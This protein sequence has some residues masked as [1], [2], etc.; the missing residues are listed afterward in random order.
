MSVQSHCG[1][2]VWRS[3]HLPMLERAREL[4]SSSGAEPCSHESASGYARFVPLHDENAAFRP[5]G[6]A[7]FDAETQGPQGPRQ[8]AEFL[9]KIAR[10]FESLF[11][12]L[13]K[14]D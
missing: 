13:I 4:F 8:P 3:F 11:Q 12:P 2:S 5:Y 6:R 10:Q 7:A 14:C 1:L 9:H